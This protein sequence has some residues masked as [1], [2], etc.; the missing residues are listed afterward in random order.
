VAAP[1]SGRS[2]PPAVARQHVIAVM[3]DDQRDAR[4]QSGLNA[5]SIVWQAPAEGGI[6]RY[7]LLFQ[8][9]LPSSV[10]PVRSSRQY[11]IAWA[12][13][14]RAMYVH[15]GGS[16]Q[17]MQTLREK[18]RGEYVFNADEFRWGPRY[19]WRVKDRFAPHNAYSDGDHLR[20]LAKRV[21]ADDGPIEA[22]WSFAP[23]APLASRPRGGT[24]S[25]PYDA[26]KIAYRYERR[27]NRYIRSV[28]GA[29]PQVD[30]A[31]GKGV[32]PKNVVV[33]FMRFG[34]LNDGHPEKKRQ[35]AQFVG[36]GKALIA[37]N[38][39][40]IQGTWRKASFT[41]PT[42]LFDA[43]GQPVTL[44]IGQ[45]FVQVIPTGTKVTVVDGKPVPRLPT[46]APRPI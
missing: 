31:D 5:A 22:V 16:P 45:T 27:G 38:G 9:R 37:T 7:M 4:P 6:P 25:V 46:V 39:R 41:A 13:E 8:D 14:W 35:E 23:D 21:G 42:L 30:R 2:V 19:I 29:D 1:L 24:I 43:A 28:T 12:A 34:P 17:A 18:G 3:V 36:S 20:Q 11:Y 44:T 32:A 15:V 26:N 33:L 10:G 40:T